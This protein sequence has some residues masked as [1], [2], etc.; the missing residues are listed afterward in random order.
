M[1]KLTVRGA[2]WRTVGIAVAL[3]L[4]TGSIGTAVSVADEDLP[5]KS[6]KKEKPAPREDVIE[7][8]SVPAITEPSGVVYHSGRGTVFV[9]SDE[10]V[11]GE[12]DL[13]GKLLSSRDIGGDL[14]GIT[15]DPS[16]GNLFV[17]REGHEILFELDPENFKILRRFTIDRAFGGDPDYLQRGGNGIEGIAFVPDESHHEGGRFFAVNQFDPAALIE[18]H[19]PLR[20]S[21]EKF[22][23]AII[24]GAHSVSASP[25][26]SLEWSGEL[27]AFLVSS[28]LWRSVH[29]VDENGASRQRVRVPGLMQEGITRIPDG[30]VI[31]Q[32]TGGLIKW[33]PASDPFASAG[34]G[35]D[36]R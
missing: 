28:S 17:I 12:V 5:P 34:S 2:R 16:T 29:V 6:E 4:A 1:P 8:W 25:L 27:R 7:E 10:G 22:E 35:G 19:L 33:I 32:D 24:V 13:N 36:D 11:I 26:S 9:V 23:K 15:Y 20:T 21:E 3:S 31:A 30:F 14:E 18:L